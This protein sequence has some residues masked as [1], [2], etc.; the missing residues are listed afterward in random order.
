VST[1]QTHRA[2]ADA[3]ASVETTVVVGA[4]L[5]SAIGSLPLHLMPLIVAALIADGRMALAEAGWV[6][7]AVLLGQLLAA[8]SLPL[9]GLR[10]VR[11]RVAVATILA[12]LLALFGTLPN[13]G[14]GVL[15]GWFVAG[16]CCGTLLYLGVTTAAASDR[17]APAFALRLGVVMIV[18][19]A[20]AVS[21]R[22]VGDVASYGSIIAA[23]TVITAIV[24]A[25]GASL[26]RATPRAVA[27]RAA[28]PRGSPRLD[29]VTGLAALLVLFVGQ[30]GFFAYAVQ[31]ATARGLPLADTALALAAMKL[32]VGIWLA[33]SAHSRIMRRSP[34]LVGAGAMLA[35]GVLVVCGAQQIAAF[36]VGLL[37]FELAFNSLSAALQARV[38]EAAP[39]LGRDWLTAGILSGAALGPPLNGIMIELG[40]GDYFIAFAVASALIP[41]LWA[42][43]QRRRTIIPGQPA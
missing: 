24:A 23:L 25:A 21:V 28:A 3:P 39:T 33:C 32:A 43:W 17:P 42:W 12:M 34:H 18:A 30:T 19:G 7:S 14:A 15:L 29:G 9:L 36:F 40:K 26:Y 10:I 22:M 38:V 35:L 27:P 2:Q 8:L 41:A 20:V 16:L 4:G 13:S 6:A 31:A 11:R 5:L 37:I 1:L